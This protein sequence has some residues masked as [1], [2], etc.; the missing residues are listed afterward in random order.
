MGEVKHLDNSN[1]DDIAGKGVALIDFWA[2]WCGPCR[3]LGPVLDEVAKEIGDDA[4]VAKINVDEAQELAAKYSVRSIPALFVLKDGEIANQ[5][6]GVQDK[7]KLI[8]AIKE[9][10]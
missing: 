1:F 5:F 10:L 9:Q 8:Q 3:M 6:V 4:V 2:E 7:Q